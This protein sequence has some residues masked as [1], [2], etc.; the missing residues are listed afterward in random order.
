MEQ[1]GVQKEELYLK[2][3]I[4]GAEGWAEST[5]TQSKINSVLKRMII[6]E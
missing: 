2:Y 6:M 3:A 1:E 5:R 4:I